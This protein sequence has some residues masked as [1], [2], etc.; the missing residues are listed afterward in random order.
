[1]TADLREHSQSASDG[2]KALAA[3][4]VQSVGGHLQS[5]KE[6]LPDALRDLP[7]AERQAMI[8]ELRDALITWGMDIDPVL[9]NLRE[10]LRKILA[11]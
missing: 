4:A 10:V 8:E 9:R 1:M 6:G 2:V 11:A 3:I 5:L 7:A